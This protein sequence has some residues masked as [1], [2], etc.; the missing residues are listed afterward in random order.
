M[1][2]IGKPCP[3]L[4]P[5]LGDADNVVTISLISD[6]NNNNIREGRILLLSL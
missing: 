6:S 3:L 5:G 4:T 1:F 2:W